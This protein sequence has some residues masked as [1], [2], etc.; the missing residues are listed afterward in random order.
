MKHFALLPHTQVFSFL[1]RLGVLVSTILFG[2]PEA[3]AGCGCTKPAP[4]PAA[5]RPNVTYGGLPV[6]LFH[7]SLAPGASYMVSFTALDGTTTSVPA[8]AVNKRDLADATYKNQLIVDVPTSLPLGPVG[9]TVTQAGQTAPFLAIPDTSFTLAPPPIVVPNQIGSFSYQNYQAAVGRDGRTYLSLDITGISMARTFQAQAQGWPLRFTKD[10]TV[11]YNIQGF[12]MQLASAPIP[13][14]FSINSGTT[15]D[16]DIAQY[17]RHEFNTYLLQHAEHLPHAVDP[18]DENW[19]QDGTRHIDHDHLILAIS[20][21]VDRAAPAAGA[22]PAFTL[23]LDALSFFQ[24][25]LVGISAIGMSGTTATDSYN[26]RTG[27]TGD[28]GDV[29]SNRGITMSNSATIN[30]NA[31][32]ASFSLSG[33]SKI[34]KRRITLTQPTSFL[35]VSVPVDLTDLGTIKL[36]KGSMRT[37]GP[38]SYQVEDVSLSGGTLVIDNATGPVTLYVTGQFTISSGQVT[39]TDPNPEKFAMYIAS[40]KQAAVN[41][42]GTF[43][44]VIF[45]PQSVVTL[46]GSGQFLG[47]FVGQQ[48]KLTGDAKVH[49]DTA[50]RGE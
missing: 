13:G 22:T 10:N 4:P 37:L 17:A 45:A 14:L 41:S 1:F 38:G 36:S 8:T 32:A 11:F 28:R 30:G 15:T 34:T 3:R 35:A 46:T 29:L 24:N 12:L 26:S 44:G 18:T 16:S 2:T 27:L 21:T 7:A 39:M 48:M 43:A 9:I 23:H 19:H 33:S 47:S 49:Y 42:N 5:V 31:T 20:G 40:T 50:L 25:G 6:T